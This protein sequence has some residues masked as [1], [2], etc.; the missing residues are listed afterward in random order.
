MLWG[1]FHGCFLLLEDFVPI[2]KLPRWIKHIYVLLV[3]LVGFVLF[4]ADTISQAGE[5]LANLFAG[6]DFSQAAMI[7]AME[8]LTPLFLVTLAVAIL[9]S[10]P[11]VPKLRSS[12][13]AQVK[14]K[15][16][17]VSF[18]ASAVVL[19]LCLLYLAGGAYNP[20][21]YFRF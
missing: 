18:V 5:M 20:F 12:L 11:I 8:Q 16:Q 21:I 19:V 9:A 2:K 3:V 10:T 6:F 4:R 1:L 15:L 13:S 17:P 7:P 14:A